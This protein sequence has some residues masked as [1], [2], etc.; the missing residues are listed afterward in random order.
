ML[1]AIPIIR[2]FLHLTDLFVLE[3]LPI[4]D[5]CSICVHYQGIPHTLPLSSLLYTVKPLNIFCEYFT[6]G[7][8]YN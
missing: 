8:Q 1:Q 3:C 6:Y 4:S 2:N 5:V 7:V